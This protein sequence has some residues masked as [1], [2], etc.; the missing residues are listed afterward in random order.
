MDDHNIIREIRQERIRQYEKWGEQN[1][2]PHI[3][4]NILVEEVGEA[5]KAVNEGSAFRYRDEL[6]QVAAVAISAIDSLDRG[7]ME[8]L[9]VTELQKENK[10]LK[11]ALSSREE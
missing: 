7:N 9:P 6:I 11:E 8:I 10:K 5:S 3:W 2:S 4:M 1:H